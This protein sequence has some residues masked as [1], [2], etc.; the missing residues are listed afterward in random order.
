MEYYLP[1]WWQRPQHPWP[2]GGLSHSL[3]A[4]PP[5]AHFL[6]VA[7]HKAGGTDTSQYNILHLYVIL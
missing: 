7:P 1:V 4:Y 6:T 2:L 3:S 5:D